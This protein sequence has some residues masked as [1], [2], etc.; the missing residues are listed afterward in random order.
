MTKAENEERY[1]SDRLGQWAGIPNTL[2]Q[3]GVVGDWVL[4]GIYRNYSWERNK[5]RRRFEHSAGFNP[6][7]QR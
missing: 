2:D 3:W 5:E 4:K 1:R 7:R 6:G